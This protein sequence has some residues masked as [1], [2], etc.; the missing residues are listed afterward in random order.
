[1]GGVLADRVIPFFSIWV[2]PRTTIR[3]VVDSDPE[4]LVVIIAWIFGALIALTFQVEINA[5]VLP[6]AAPAW[7]ERMGPAAIGMTVFSSGIATVGLVY[8]LGL[9]YGRA[10][11]ALGGIADSRDV[12]SAI[13][14]GWVPTILLSL[15]IMTAALF[16]PAA[17]AWEKAPTTILDR[18]NVW[19]IAELSIAVWAIFVSVETLAEVHRFSSG[20][21]I[22]T[23]AVGALVLAFLG[24]GIFIVMTIVSLIVSLM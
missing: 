11:R 8:F 14:W 9:L 2:V 19:N 4:S 20:R 18:V 1:M 5:G 23:K 6:F 7:L 12:R 10:G 3:R 24:V 15:V 22:G 21:A 13:A 17:S 16:A